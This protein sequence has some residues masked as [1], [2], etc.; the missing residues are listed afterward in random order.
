MLVWV[1]TSLACYNAFCTFLENDMEELKVSSD[2][3]FI[4]LGAI[5]VLAINIGARIL[6]RS[7]DNL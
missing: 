4:L 5:M 1:G 6:F 3:L 7:K 2:A